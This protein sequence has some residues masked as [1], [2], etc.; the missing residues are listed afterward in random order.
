[1]IDLELKERDPF[2]ATRKRMVAVQIE[3]RGLRSPEVLAAM[4]TVPRHLF[5]PSNL[6]EQAYEDRALPLG[7]QQTISQPYIV[8]LMT[9][10][11]CEGSRDSVLEIGTGS[12]Y[13]SAVLAELFGDV[14][15]VEVDQHR[16]DCAESNLSRLHYKNVHL[17]RADGNAGWPEHAPYDAILVTASTRQASEDLRN[18]LRVGGRL[19]VPCT[20]SNRD[21]QMLRVMHKTGPDSWQEHDAGAVRFVPMREEK[22]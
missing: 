6:M 3:A 10:L 19:I 5:V 18:Q 17:L 11:A 2:L 12:G 16:F 15:S 1:M 22:L 20:K 13:Q 7:P 14:F 9:E 4:R 21:E 8:A